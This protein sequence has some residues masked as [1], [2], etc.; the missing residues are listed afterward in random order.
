MHIK[1]SPSSVR[2]RYLNSCDTVLCLEQCRGIWYRIILK[3][4]H[5][6][7]WHLKSAG[8]PALWENRHRTKIPSNSKRGFT[9]KHDFGRNYQI[10]YLL[11]NMQVSL[12]FPFPFYTTFKNCRRKFTFRGKFKYTGPFNS[13][14]NFVICLGTHYED[15]IVT[16]YKTKQKTHN[17]VV[18]SLIKYSFS[19]TRNLSK[20]KFSDAPSHYAS[21]KT[22]TLPISSIEA[23][24][25]HKLRF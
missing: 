8:N 17:Q 7:L 12:F 16:N 15:G 13:Q 4:P 18:T 9:K 21:T 19:C 11:V 2:D 24:E 3:A 20:H 22:F 25:E 14:Q 10:I 23:L 1:T 5:R 6:V